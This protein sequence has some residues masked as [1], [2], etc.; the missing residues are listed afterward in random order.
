MV[1]KV[2]RRP[3]VLILREAVDPRRLAT[4]FSGAGAKPNPNSHVFAPIVLLR[5]EDNLGQDYPQAFIEKVAA[6]VFKEYSRMKAI[7]P[8]ILA[9]H[10]RSGAMSS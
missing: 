10:F 8:N 3:A 2:K 4:H 5:K 6:K 9:P 1:K 7:A